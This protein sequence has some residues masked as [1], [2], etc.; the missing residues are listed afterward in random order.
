MGLTILITILR[1]C[2][3]MTGEAQR[4]AVSELTVE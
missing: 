3:G 4:R 1:F 2:R